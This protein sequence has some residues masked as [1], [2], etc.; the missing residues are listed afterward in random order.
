MSFIYLIHYSF[1]ISMFNS[2]SSQLFTM[3]RAALALYSLAWRP[4]MAR[5]CVIFSSLILP[6]VISYLKA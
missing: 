1:S 4:K 5:S 6:L 2:H 3:V